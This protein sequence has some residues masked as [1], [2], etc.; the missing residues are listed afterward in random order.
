M[1]AG[2]DGSAPVEAAEVYNPA[3]RSWRQLS[4]MP[5]GRW[6]PGAGA[7]NGR[8][9]VVGGREELTVAWNQVYVP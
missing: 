5:T 2:Y 9:Y 8:I 3:T 7:I 4:A 6:S 1:T